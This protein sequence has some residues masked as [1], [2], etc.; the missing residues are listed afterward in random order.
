MKASLLG[1]MRKLLTCS[2]I[3]PLTFSFMSLSLQAND[4][5]DMVEQ[6]NIEV[7]KKIDLTNNKMDALYAIEELNANE[8]E[9][10]FQLEN[11]LDE[12]YETLM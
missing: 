4:F 8:E 3:A 5:D 6:H 9:Q 7:Q 12:L 1:K 10:L 2:V 11:S